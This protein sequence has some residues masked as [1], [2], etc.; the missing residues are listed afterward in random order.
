VTVTPEQRAELLERLEQ[1]DLAL[2][3][4]LQARRDQGFPDRVAPEVLDQAVE[5]LR[6]G[7]RTRRST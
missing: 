4:L 6:S 5:I 2:E 7:R 1:G 3:I